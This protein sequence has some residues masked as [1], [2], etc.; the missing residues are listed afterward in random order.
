M[1]QGHGVQWDSPVT[2]QESVRKTGC[3]WIRCYTRSKPEKTRIRQPLS[4]MTELSSTFLQGISKK[5]ARIRPAASSTTP[6]RHQALLKKASIQPRSSGLQ[7][8]LTLSAIAKEA[9]TLTL[10]ILIDGKTCFYML[11][12]QPGETSGRRL[13]PSKALTPLHLSQ[14]LLC[15]GQESF[16]QERRPRAECSQ[17]SWTKR[18]ACKGAARKKH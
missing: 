3:L 11:L 18:S 16:K 7:D 9:C 6:R 13:S 14:L 2:D 17:S 8:I 12:L 10:H 15:L 1:I 5:S 4:G